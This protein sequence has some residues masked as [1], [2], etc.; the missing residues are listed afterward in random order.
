MH[1]MTFAPS[2]NLFF[3]VGLGKLMGAFFPWDRACD[4]EGDSR[5]D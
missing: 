4:A 1:T 2:E 3:C 5:T